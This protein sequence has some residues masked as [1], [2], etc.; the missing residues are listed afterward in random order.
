MNKPKIPVDIIL[1]HLA[2]QA[3]VSRERVQKATDVLLGNLDTDIAATPYEVVLHAAIVGDSGRFKR[4]DV[5][6]ESWRIM[7]PLIDDPPPV[8]PYVPGTWGPAIASSL[9]A[10]HGGWQGPW[11]VEPERAGR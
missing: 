7:Q 4:Q 11:I 10:G 8:H 2:D 3:E 6:E 9:V 5:V 1:K